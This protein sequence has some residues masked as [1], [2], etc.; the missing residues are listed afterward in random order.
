MVRRLFVLLALMAATP[1]AGGAVALAAS[2]AES[3]SASPVLNEQDRTFLVDAHQ[4]NLAEIQA[5]R[6]AE[7]QGT[8]QAIRDA[9]TTL[10]RDHGKLDKDVMRVA[11]KLGVALPD[12]PTKKQQAQLDAFAAKAGT[13]FD[14]KWVSAEIADHRGDLAAGKQEVSDGSS[15]QVKELAKGAKPVVQRHLEIL[16]SIKGGG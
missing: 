15:Q 4:G 3:P 16:K 10:V 13:A 12:K 2:A 9:G 8:T 5:G 11:D 14:K 7:K 1:V 6:L